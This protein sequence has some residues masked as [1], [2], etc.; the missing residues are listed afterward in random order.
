MRMKQQKVHKASQSQNTHSDIQLA[1]LM[2]DD[3]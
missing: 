3:I 2:K 1:R